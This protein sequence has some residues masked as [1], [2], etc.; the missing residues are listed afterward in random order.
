MPKKQPTSAKKARTAARAGAKYTSA[1]RQM[2]DTLPSHLELVDSHALSEGDQIVVE[3]LRE[4]AA[5]GVPLPLRFAEPDP[6]V[7]A[8]RSEA[9]ASGRRMRWQRW[10]SVEAA[11]DGYVL[12]EVQYGPNRSG[13]T[14]TN[15]GPRVPVP[16]LAADGAVT[17]V[18]MPEW[19]SL[20][21]DRWVWAH[22]GWPIETPGRI[23]DPPQVF[24]PAPDLRWQVAAWL[25]MGM[26]GGGVFGEDYGGSLGGWDTVAWCTNREDACQIARAY[27]AHRSHYARADVLQHGADLGVVSLTTD[28]FVQAPDAP[29]LARA[30]AAPGPRPQSPPYSEIPEP[31][32]HGATKHPPNV[33][34]HV[35][36]GDT[37]RLLAW[38]GWQAAMIA[39]KLGI[40]QNGPYLWAEDWGPHHPDK[41]MHDWTQEGRTLWGRFPEPTHEERTEMYAENRRARETALVEWLAARSNGTLTREQAAARLKAG[42]LRY[43]DFLR[44]GQ[45]V[46]LDPLHRRRRELPQGPERTAIRDLIERVELHD[47]PED[48]IQDTLDNLSENLDHRNTSPEGRPWLLRA[49]SEYL[50]PSANT[51]GVDGLDPAVR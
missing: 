16:V 17:M 5:S 24:A 40:G 34:L 43:R 49:L 29:E 18:A 21:E 15:R 27:T 32:W 22:T 20:L 14:K 23:V 30:T 4:L 1:L 35:W 45:V 3:C 6:E 28:T 13:Y 38:T 33:S 12:R 47:V 8:A 39:H 31:A 9:A 37:W 48:L 10:A 44:V 50:T 11:V 41:D 26:N 42:G 46:I 2:Q 7:T 19:A 51:A 25:D 36:T